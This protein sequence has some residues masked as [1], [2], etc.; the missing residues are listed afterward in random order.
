MYDG[1]VRVRGELGLSVYLSSSPW[2]PCIPSICCNSRSPVSLNIDSSSR[3]D[4]CKTSF[5]WCEFICE[6][7]KLVRVTKPK[8]TACESSINITILKT[9][10]NPRVILVVWGSSW[11]RLQKIHRGFFQFKSERCEWSLNR[12]VFQPVSERCERVWLCMKLV[13]D[14]APSLTYKPVKTITRSVMRSILIHIFKYR[15][16]G[17]TW[18]EQFKDLK[19]HRCVRVIYENRLRVS[20]WTQTK[21]GQPK[22][23]ASLRKITNKI[24]STKN[25][26]VIEKDH[27]FHKEFDYCN[28]NWWIYR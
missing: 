7:V 12:R 26:R 15:T 6:V 17:V 21:Y 3:F 14:P 11:G 25:T 28:H 9:K 1:G 20:R 4:I 22:T 16:D 13:M 5:S 23:C 2:S 27:K 19:T 18:S 24:W 10:T 8:A